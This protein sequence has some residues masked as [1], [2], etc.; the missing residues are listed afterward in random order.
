[1]YP[2]KRKSKRTA[3]ALHSHR[4]TRS[5]PMTITLVQPEKQR[6]PA[7]SHVY[8]KTQ[9]N[10]HSTLVSIVPFVTQYSF[11]INMSTCRVGVNLIFINHAFQPWLFIFNRVAIFI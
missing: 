5:H 9:H 3:A 10:E 2:I 4:M 1:M 6:M 8:R 7:A 11:S